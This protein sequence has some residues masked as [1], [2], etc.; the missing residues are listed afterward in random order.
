MAAERLLSAG[1]AAALPAERLRAV[2]L[3]LPATQHI[4]AQDVSPL[5]SD[6]SWKVDFFVCVCVFF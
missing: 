6:T 2:L 1:R 5:E 3:T 4:S